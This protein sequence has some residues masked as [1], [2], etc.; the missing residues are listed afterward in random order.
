M[1]PA[2]PGEPL[3]AAGSDLYYAL[4]YCPPPRAPVAALLAWHARIARV[5]LESSDDAV[6]V[7]QLQWWH[8]EIARLGGGTARHPLTLALQ[9]AAGTQATTAMSAALVAAGALVAAPPPA[10]AEALVA[11]WQ[12]VGAPLWQQ[13]AQWLSAPAPPPDASLAPLAGLAGAAA[14]LRTAGRQ[15]QVGRW[16]LPSSSTTTAG[17]RALAAELAVALDEARAAVPAALRQPL[18]PL[19]TLAAIEARTLRACAAP[20]VDPLRSRVALT[21][22]RKLWIARAERR[23]ARRQ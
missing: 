21:P 18:L 6:A 20:D 23:R 5:L 10:D 17:L 9:A 13:V 11:R 8:E 16:A 14:A 22:L 3:I 7:A 19:V 15:R 1:P 4:L 2:D 12:A